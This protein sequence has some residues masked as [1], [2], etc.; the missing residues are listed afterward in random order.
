MATAVKL[1]CHVSLGWTP[2]ESIGLAGGIGIGIVIGASF[3]TLLK[4]VAVKFGLEKDRG[5]EVIPQPAEAAATPDK[6]QAIQVCFDATGGNNS[7]T[8]TEKPGT[9]GVSSM[10]IRTTPSSRDRIIPKASVV[11][12]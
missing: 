1:F 9:G 10:V 2:L 3:S 7:L 8:G 11:N 6:A 5:F 12:T 4:L